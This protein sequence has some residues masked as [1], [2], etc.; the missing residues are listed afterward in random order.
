[1]LV[2][3]SVAP[4]ELADRAARGGWLRSGKAGEADALGVDR[5]ICPSAPLRVALWLRGPRS[6]LS[7]SPQSTE[8]ETPSPSNQT[9][10]PLKQSATPPKHRST[11]GEEKRFLFGPGPLVPLGLRRRAR[12]A[13]RTCH[14][15]RCRPSLPRPATRCRPPP[16]SGAPGLA[17]ASAWSVSPPLCAGAAEA[18][19]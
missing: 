9:R 8:S 10:E 1:M 11:E 3:P 4:F 15:L 16:R 2:S 7:S 13:A 18:V 19:G 6:G 14:F 5:M 17:P 12:T